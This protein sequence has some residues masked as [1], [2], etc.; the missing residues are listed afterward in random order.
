MVNDGHLTAI[1][2]VIVVITVIGTINVL[3]IFIVLQLM[4]ALPFMLALFLKL[5]LLFKSV[6]LLKLCSE[7]FCRV[8]TNMRSFRTSLP[9]PLLRE[10]LQAQN[11]SAKMIAIGKNNT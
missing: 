11:L 10:G 8:W 7:F 2:I 9:A 6:L 3:I 5:L 4:L 1:I